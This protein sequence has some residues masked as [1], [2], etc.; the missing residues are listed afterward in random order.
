MRVASKLD[1]NMLTIIRRVRAD[2]HYP[3]RSFIGEIYNALLETYRL[4]AEG[5]F[6]KKVPDSDSKLASR[7]SR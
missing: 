2:A 1:A 4:G 3:A 7:R 5:R 6:I